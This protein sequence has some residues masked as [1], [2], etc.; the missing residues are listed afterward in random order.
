[1][2]EAFY[3]LSRK[4]FSMLP[5]PGFLY[6]SKKHETALTLL[7]YALMN[8]AGFCV[9]T[10]EPGAGKTTLLHKLLEAV[11]D[12]VAVGMITN[13]H[14][15]FGELLDWVLSA[16]SIHESGL[17][18]VEKNQ[19]F[20][21]FLLQQYAAGKSTLLIVDEA[22]NMPADT[23]EELRMLSNVN[24][25]GDLVLQV[26]L[27]GQPALKATLLQPELM[28]FAQ[29]IAVDY[30]LDALSLGETCGYIQHRLLTA[31]AIRDVFTPKACEHIYRYSGGTPRLI[32]LICDTAMVY[33][34]ADQA[35][36]IDENMIDEMVRERM[37]DSVVPLFQQVDAPVI[38]DEAELQSIEDIEFPSISG[39]LAQDEPVP[40]AA[41]INAQPVEAEK[42][43]LT[44]PESVPESETVTVTTEATA[45][46]EPAPE[47]PP[48]VSDTA[49]DPVA[50]ATTQTA[51][52][53]AD[54][55]SAASEDPQDEFVKTQ[56]IPPYIPP[57]PKPRWLWA[58]VFAVGALLLGVAVLLIQQN[59]A[60]QRRIA[61]QAMQAEI[62]KQQLF[63]NR[64]EDELSALRQQ[65]QEDALR[66]Q[67]QADNLQQQR[68]AALDEARRQAEQREALNAQIDSIKADIAR[69]EKQLRREAARALKAERE[70]NTSLARKKDEL[71]TE[72][73][74]QKAELSWLV[75]QL[76][77]NRLQ[78]AV[79]EEPSE[80]LDALVVQQPE[81]AEEIKE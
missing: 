19:R 39:M 32:N 21:D 12:N 51:S 78:Q 71:E 79:V 8:H 42:K 66:L 46:P 41:A 62:A 64:L 61:D 37:K 17:N 74:E 60:E 48:A 2:Y 34:F 56:E 43:T 49:A 11:E 16:Y 76:E 22:Q 6:L 63:T 77:Q 14:K 24:S 68:D 55:T 15:S 9:V 1:M 53:T 3:G 58:S 36:L 72:L 29:R 10:G 59:F 35:E 31:G 4:P 26:I 50:P 81:L 45:Q 65:Q 13:T 70:K 5:D 38:P 7:E 80:P 30:H 40:V 20:I 25:E 52:T 33:G 28:Q 75:D 67:A 44:E 18:Q 57:A 47:P 23:L 69:Q 27:A 54:E 73:Q